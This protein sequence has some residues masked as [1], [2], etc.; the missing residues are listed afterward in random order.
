MHT[1]ETD[2]LIIG[3]GFGGAAPALR[4]AEAGFRVPL[5]EQGPRLDPYRDFRQT[6]D[7]KY[8]LKYIKGISGERLHLTYAEALGGRSG[9]Y[10]MV[11]LRAPSQA[12]A[13]VRSEA[14]TSELQ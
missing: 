5:I 10:E 14:H 4:F 3:T 12:F 1:V 13:R 11:S 9:F 7:P 8:I 6:Q 2:V